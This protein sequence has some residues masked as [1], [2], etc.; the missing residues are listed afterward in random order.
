MGGKKFE[1]DQ[2]LTAPGEY[3]LRTNG[4]FILAGESPEIPVETKKATLKIET[5]LLLG[6]GASGGM[7]YPRA[8]GTSYAKSGVGGASGY[9]NEP[10]SSGS[11]YLPSITKPVITVGK[12]GDGVYT[13]VNTFYTYIDSKNAYYIAGNS[14]GATKFSDASG[15]IYIAN[16]AE[17][18]SVEFTGNWPNKIYIYVQSG[19]GKNAGLIGMLGDYVINYPSNVDYYSKGG[20]GNPLAGAAGGGG[21]SGSGSGGYGGNPGALTDTSAGAPGGGGSGIDI[22]N[23]GS[24]TSVAGSGSGGNGYCRIVCSVTLN[25]GG[26]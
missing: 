9:K 1:V 23:D 24:I 18:A 10:T 20:D 4:L 17:K 13:D 25:G 5:L 12:G 14:G 21:K 15:D 2:E 6:A 19:S 11:I 8:D 22:D 3:T 16:G 7:G 26:G